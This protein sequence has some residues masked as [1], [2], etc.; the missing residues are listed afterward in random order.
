MSE[1][2]DVIRTE[3]FALVEELSTLT[4]EQ[5]ATPSLCAGWTVQDVAAHLAWASTL[6]ARTLVGGL[7]RARFR[8]NHL[9]SESAV[10]WSRQG[11]AA[12]LGQ[13]RV[14]AERDTRPFG[15]STDAVLTDVVVHGMDIRRPLGRTRPVPPL[16]FFRIASQCT[17]AR[18][19]KSALLGGAARNRLAG[20]RLVAEDLGWA[21][22][23]GPEVRGSAEAVLLV[24]TGRPV[25]ADKLGGPGAATL[26][27]RC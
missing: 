7:V 14:H 11:T 24:L 26:A 4:P 6:R 8:P 15:M 27:A 17:G 5:W 20:I 10:R 13:L 16:A 2:W 19:P 23:D 1:V 21:S 9:I 25:R 18:W 12:I 22:G 3:R